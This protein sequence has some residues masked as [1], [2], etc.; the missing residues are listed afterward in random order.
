[1][2]CSCIIYPISVNAENA[3]ITLNNYETKIF[4]EIE[5]LSGY[6]TDNAEIVELKNT[7]SM[8]K[9]I[10]TEKA[11]KI[12]VDDGVIIIVPK[13]S[14]NN[15]ILNSFDYAKNKLMTRDSNFQVTHLV[16]MIINMSCL[17]NSTYDWNQ[18]VRL[19]T[20]KGMY[21]S[22]TSNN[23]TAGVEDILIKFDANGDYWKINPLTNMG[24]EKYVSFDIYEVDPTE[25]IVYGD[26]EAAMNDNYGL[27]LTDYFNH[28]GNISYSI[29]YTVN[30]VTRYDRYSWVPFSK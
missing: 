26:N 4:N 1:M 13:I 28:G 6:N 11:I 30:G 15:E 17:Y 19:Y 8:N 5:K 20:P 21:F 23:S 24:Y 7:N 22:W 9:N 14:E 10:T 27:V 16:D 12:D 3:N 18:L 25:S 29:N 2:L